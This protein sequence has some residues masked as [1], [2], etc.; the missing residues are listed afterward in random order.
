MSQIRPPWS[1]YNAR[2]P[3]FPTSSPNGTPLFLPHIC[4]PIRAPHSVFSPPL[5]DTLSPSII[6]PRDTLPHSCSPAPYPTPQVNNSPISPDSSSRHPFFPHSFLPSG[7]QIPPVPWGPLSTPPDSSLRAA[8]LLACS[9]DYSS[10]RVP[11]PPPLILPIL[12]YPFP[13]ENSRG[14]AWVVVPGQVHLEPLFF[15]FWGHC[16]NVPELGAL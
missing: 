7:L 15:G 6:A 2:H 11:P 13:E 16:Q 3:S 8:Q 10:A 9:R 5:G 1:A 4:S 14:G 12:S